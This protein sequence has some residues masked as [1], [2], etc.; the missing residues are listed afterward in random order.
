M[1]TDLEL[2][3]MALDAYAD[4]SD[5]DPELQQHSPLTG[6]EVPP[7]FRPPAPIDSGFYGRCTTMV[8]KSLSPT[9]GRQISMKL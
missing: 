4:P 8:A 9:A 2:A 3:L 7:G 5:P 1:A 6:W